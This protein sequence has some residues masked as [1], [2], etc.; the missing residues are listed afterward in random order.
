M[1][2]KIKVRENNCSNCAKLLTCPEILT[3]T[4]KNYAR[5]E[6]GKIKEPDKPAISRR[7]K[8][9]VKLIGEGKSVTEIAAQLE[10]DRET[11]ARELEY[12]NKSGILE[13]APSK[14]E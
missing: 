11:V 12:L 2:K 6:L 4:C 10:L 3:Y 5:A 1:D 14:E 9:I 13:S 7:N 8:E